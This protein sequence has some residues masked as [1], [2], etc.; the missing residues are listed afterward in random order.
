MIKGEANINPDIQKAQSNRAQTV[1]DLSFE[2]VQEG[3]VDFNTALRILNINGEQSEQELLEKAKE[4]IKR[5]YWWLQERWQ[6]KGV[7]R[8]QISIRIGDYSVE[9]YNYGQELTLTQMEELQNIM[10]VLAQIPGKEVKYVVID[11]EQ[12]FN[13][14]NQEDG[15]GYAYPTQSMIALYPRAMS[16][17]PHRIP[18]TSGFIGTL[19]HEYAHVLPEGNFWNDWRVQFG[20]K[21]LS[22]IDYSKSAPK[23]YSTDQESRCVTDYAKFSPD[24]DICESLVAAVNNPTTLDDERL[25]FIQD[26][27]LKDIRPLSPDEISIAR[28]SKEEVVLPKIPETVK[29]KIRASTF[30]I[31]EQQS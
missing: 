5:K 6:R 3:D 10:A 29:Y 16:G 18:N 31:Q 30:I 24:E 12:A 9:L 2:V 19:V 13:D 25:Q 14:Q 8:E 20:W 17:E 4:E 27:W 26:R 28:K 22:E 1:D 7:P 11:N 23:S 15:R 21:P